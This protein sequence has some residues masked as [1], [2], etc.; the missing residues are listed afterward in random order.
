MSILI[1]VI[2]ALV[3]LGLALYAV[4]RSPIPSPVNW[5]IQ[6]LLIVVAIVFIGNRAGFF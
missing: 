4:Q 1:T 2:I 5:L 3:L 6:L